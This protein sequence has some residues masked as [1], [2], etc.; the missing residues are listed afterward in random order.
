[1]DSYREVVRRKSM[2]DIMKETCFDIISDAV[3]TNSHG[4]CSCNPPKENCRM[5]K[6]Y[7]IDGREIKKCSGVVFEFWQPTLDKL[8]DY[9]GLLSTFYP[10]KK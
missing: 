3:F 7:T 1:M 4:D 5:R 10:N 8:P 2:D 6:A 9:M